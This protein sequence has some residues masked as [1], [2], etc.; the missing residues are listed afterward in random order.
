MP[1]TTRIHQHRRPEEV[2]RPAPGVRTAG[3][4]V[5]EHKPAGGPGVLGQSLA[6]TPSKTTGTVPRK[7]V[8]EPVTRRGRLVLA[9]TA[10]D[11]ELETANGRFE[12]LG[13]YGT[14][15]HEGDEVEVTG[16]PDPTARH[17]HTLPAMLVQQMRR[18]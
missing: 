18:I 17:P 9:P 15:A 13:P 6:T 14:E 5:L 12:L 3:P 7:R 2:G 11:L 1:E 8:L 16:L 4:D 10:E